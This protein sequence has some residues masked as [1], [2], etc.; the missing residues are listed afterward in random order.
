MTSENTKIKRI[1]EL[2]RAV[3]ERCSK[4]IGNAKN[5]GLKPDVEPKQEEP[6]ITSIF[7]RKH[8]L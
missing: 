4:R 7:K 1:E 8:G 3:I 5:K 2:K 6:S